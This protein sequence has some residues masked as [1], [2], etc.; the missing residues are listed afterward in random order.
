MKMSIDSESKPT[1]KNVVRR[2]PRTRS[3]SEAEAK[4]EKVHFIKFLAIYF[5]LL[6]SFDYNVWNGI[7]NW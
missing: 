7:A 1:K 2:R 4:E 3:Q 5:F 6:H